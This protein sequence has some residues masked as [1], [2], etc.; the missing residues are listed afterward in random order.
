MPVTVS[1]APLN[2]DL[3]ALG[4]KAQR[5]LED[6]LTT[7]PLVPVVLDPYTAESASLLSTA[8][9]VLVSYQGAGCRTCW[10]LTCDDEGAKRFLGPWSS[11]ILTF[12]DPNRELIKGLGL[13]MLPAFLFVLQDGSIA[14]TAQGWNPQEWRDVAEA[15]SE[16]TKWARPVIGDERD[17]NPFEGTPA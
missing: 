10:I 16:V 15:V 11:D 6:W 2:V 8:R 9:R 7:F 12:T 3:S 1:T 4:G 17:P 13:T 5:P 14:A